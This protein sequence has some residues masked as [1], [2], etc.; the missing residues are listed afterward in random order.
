MATWVGSEPVQEEER[1]GERERERERGH[2][3]EKDTELHGS[4][5][6]HFM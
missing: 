2:R 5:L 1:E 3:H 4:F 6:R